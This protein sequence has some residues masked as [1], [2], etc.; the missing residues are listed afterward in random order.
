MRT[1]IDLVLHYLRPRDFRWQID[2]HQAKGQGR[3]ALVV[4]QKRS[5]TIDI[6]YGRITMTVERQPQGVM[7]TGLYHQYDTSP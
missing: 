7:I 1:Y 6:R 5:P 3:F 2:Y 4:Q